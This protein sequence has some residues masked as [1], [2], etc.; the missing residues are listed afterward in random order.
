[1]QCFLDNYLLY[2]GKNLRLFIDDFIARSLPP[3]SAI[4]A[5]EYLEETFD[6]TIIDQILVGIESFLMNTDKQTEDWERGKTLYFKVQDRFATA[7]N[8]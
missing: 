4:E 3:T 1:M 7:D 2:T 5:F 8:I 6:D